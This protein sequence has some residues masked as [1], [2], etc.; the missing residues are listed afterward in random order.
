MNEAIVHSI[1]TSITAVTIQG[2]QHLIAN[3]PRIVLTGDRQFGDPH[4]TA[5]ASADGSA[6]SPAAFGS[7]P[8]GGGKA[9]AAMDP[10]ACNLAHQGRAAARLPTNLS[11]NHCFHADVLYGHFSI[12]THQ[13]GGSGSR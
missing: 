6:R 10:K 13:A 9:D 3:A 1:P 7:T 5:I 2:E 11:T 8:L 4:P 12:S